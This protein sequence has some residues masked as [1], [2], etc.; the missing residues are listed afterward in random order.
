MDHAG[1]AGEGEARR[2][3]PLRGRDVEVLDAAHTLGD[4][5]RSV[6]PMR[7]GEPIATSTPPKMRQHHELVAVAHRSSLRRSIAMAHSSTV[8]PCPSR[9]TMPPNL[10]PFIPTSREAVAALGFE[11]G[12]RAA[13]G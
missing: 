6:F 3:V 11:S 2:R 7:S 5:N 8:R 4:S 12:R 1:Q 10:A 9:P 13:R